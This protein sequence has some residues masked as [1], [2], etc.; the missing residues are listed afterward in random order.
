MPYPRETAFETVEEALAYLDQRRIV[1]LRCGKTYRALGRH[2]SRAHGWTAREY[3]DF[4]A[5]PY[6]RGLSCTR[7]RE[8][9]S[10]LGRRLQENY[11]MEGPRLANLL[12]SRNTEN[13]PRTSVFASR[14]AAKN[15]SECE[16]KPW[17]WTP[18]SYDA[19]L[20][21]MKEQ[22]RGF[23]DVAGDSDMPSRVSVNNFCAANPAFAAKLSLICEPRRRK[24]K[25]N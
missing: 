20:D 1:C 16:H 24:L 12:A 6:Q 9:R 17:K 10:A 2:L 7:T 25:S 23:I 15:S 11:P 8:L 21:R 5:L 22:G 19:L 18:E 14:Q 13:L 3:K 4:Y